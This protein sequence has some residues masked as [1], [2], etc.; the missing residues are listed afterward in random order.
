MI[1]TIRSVRRTWL[2]AV[3]VVLGA[4]AGWAGPAQEYLRLYREII[5]ARRA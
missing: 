3:L 1:S 4:G 5:A 2:P